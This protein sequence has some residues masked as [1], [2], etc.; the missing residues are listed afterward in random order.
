MITYSQRHCSRVYRRDSRLKISL[1]GR[2]AEAHTKGVS[3]SASP[4]GSAGRTAASLV[5]PEPLRGR[6]ARLDQA[7]GTSPLIIVNIVQIL[8][9]AV[10]FPGRCTEPSV[11]TAFIIIV[12]FVIV[13]LVRSCDSHI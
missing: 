11:E 1:A 9:A 3:A 10:V 7:A 6:Y 12:I 5:K 4:I 13:F 8:S 2:Q